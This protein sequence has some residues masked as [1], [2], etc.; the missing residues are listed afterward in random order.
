MLVRRL[1]N[2]ILLFHLHTACTNTSYCCSTCT[3]H[4]LTS[5]QIKPTH[6]SKRTFV[7]M[8]HA[9]QPN[10]NAHLLLWRTLINQPRNYLLQARLQKSTSNLNRRHRVISDVTLMSHDDYIWLNS[11]LLNSQCWFMAGAK[12]NYLVLL[13]WMLFFSCH[14]RISSSFLR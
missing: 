8:A 6:A 3:R 7:T 10:Q 4:A 9:N 13:F 12:Q 2:L 5:T 11:R 1:L 14:L